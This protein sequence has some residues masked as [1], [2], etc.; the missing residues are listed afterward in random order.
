MAIPLSTTHLKVYFTSISVISL[1]LDLE[2]TVIPN[3][4]CDPGLPSPD[5]QDGAEE[6]IF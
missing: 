3:K 6:I 5:M 1:I 4:T 2:L